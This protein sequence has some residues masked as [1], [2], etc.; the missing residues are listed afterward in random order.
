MITDLEEMVSLLGEKLEKQLMSPKILLGHCRLIDESSRLTSAYTDPFYL[1]FYYHLGNI[2]QPKT[3]V[4]FGFRLGLAA[5]CFFRSCKSVETFL[6][7]QEPADSTFYSP[8]LAKA[9]VRDHYK[10]NLIVHA[11]LITETKFLNSFET[12]RWDLAIID[13]EVGYDRCMAY[14]DA[15]WARVSVDGLIVVDHLSRNEA[16]RKALMDFA[17]S[18][19]REPALLKT[20]YGVGIIQR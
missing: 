12:L 2:I 10:S 7:V 3:V 8:R 13:D 14:L 16:G 19:N 15:L 1:P 6:A 4:E 17:R 11:G 5:S 9:N 18:N 20:R